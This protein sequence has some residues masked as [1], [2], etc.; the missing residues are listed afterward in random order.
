MFCPFDKIV[1]HPMYFE[2]AQKKTYSDE[3]AETFDIE[4]RKNRM[5]KLMNVVFIAR[6]TSDSFIIDFRISDVNNPLSLAL[7]LYQSY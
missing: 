6:S 4:A 5:N 7:I 1:L 2:P 3:E